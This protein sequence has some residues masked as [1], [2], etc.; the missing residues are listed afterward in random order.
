MDNGQ[1]SRSS[2]GNATGA[3]LSLICAEGFVIADSGDAGT[4]IADSE[5]AG[6]VI[7]DSGD[8]ATQAN[9]RCGA[10]S[11][12]LPEWRELAVLRCVGEEFGDSIYLRCRACRE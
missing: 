2:N 1:V 7:A 9:W 12:A 4:V 10:N 11:S 8:A 3:E 6:T 5:D